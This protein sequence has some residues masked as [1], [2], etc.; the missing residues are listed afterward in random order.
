MKF[1]SG[2]HPWNR[3]PLFPF[4]SPLSFFCHPVADSHFRENI[5]R[6]RRIF[7]QFPS[8]ICHVYAQNLI[9]ALY[10][11][12]PD[13]CQNAVVG[14]HASGVARQK[15]DKTVF[16]LS[17]VDAFSVQKHEAL[18]EI[19]SQLAAYIGTLVEFCVGIQPVAVPECC[20]DARQKLGCAE[21]LGDIVVGSRVERKNFFMLFG[22]GRNDDD[23]QAGPGAYFTDDFQSV[24]IRQ[25]QI[26]K[27][28][29]TASA[30]YN[31]QAFRSCGGCC[32]LVTL[33]PQGSLNKITDIFFI[34]NNQYRKLAH[35]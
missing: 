3:L 34:F 5:L 35:N 2:P 11:G 7:L 13:L 24:R 6:V 23:G 8:D 21:G 32:D 1:L 33:G 19:Y 17:Q 18:V 10:I 22:S 27:H 14:Q 28:Q 26:Q 15:R 12:A 16:D 20:P 9:V 4:F 31:G 30:V 25:S 29:I